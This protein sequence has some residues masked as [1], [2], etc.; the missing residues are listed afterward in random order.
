MK[1]VFAILCV[2]ALALSCCSCKRLNNNNSNFSDAASYIDFSSQETAPSA[3]VQNDDNDIPSNNQS[4][5]SDNTQSVASST[6]TN[7]SN[8]DNSNAQS[9]NNSIE[10]S[11][12]KDTSTTQD[13][14]LTA[15]ST[16]ASSDDVGSIISNGYIY[17]TNPRSDFPDGLFRKQIIGGSEEIV[18]NLN[19]TYYKV[20]NETVYYIHLSN[21]YSCSPDG[22]NVK[23]LYDNISSFEVAGNWIF[24]IRRLNNTALGEIVEELYMIST[25]GNIT[26][27]IKP[28]ASNE[29]GSTVTIH[30]FNRG[31]CYLTVK[32]L[33]YV[34]GEANTIS[35]SNDTML[36]RVDYRSKELSQQNLKINTEYTYEDSK[37]YSFD[38]S[39]I[40]IVNDRVIQSRGS[41]K[42]AVSLL[43]NTAA[44]V[45]ESQMA[46]PQQALKDYY[47]YIPEESTTKKYSVVFTNYNGNKKTYTFNWTK[48]NMN[49][50]QFYSYQ[51]IYKNSLLLLLQN[52]TTDTYSLQMID[53]NGQ[54]VEIYTKSLQ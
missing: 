19:V 7:T 25:D 46:L 6:Q 27:R 11:K 44:T 18:T 49:S 53:S 12:N 37:H 21:L 23:K 41:E 43:N 9:T 17:Y 26:K 4:I 36:L 5:I 15:D 38:F 52:T 28:D 35:M 22:S 3:I 51:D 20:L 1:K 16:R 2:L 54:V 42:W 40:T 24:A 34:S 45:Y 39:K 14:Y 29:A 33:F 8:T 13:V 10:D 47:V 48:N 31:Y 32:H 30:G 50:C